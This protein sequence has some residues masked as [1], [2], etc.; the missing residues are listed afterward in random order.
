[1]D[2]A[3]CEPLEEI[4]KRVQFNRIN[5]EGTSLSEEVLFPKVTFNYGW[6]LSSVT[7]YT[8][9]SHTNEQLLLQSSIILFDMLEY[10]E[11]TKHINISSNPNIGPR[12][13]Q[14]C[15]YMIKKVVVTLNS[16]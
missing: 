1:M 4:L 10:Y 9:K 12:G 3:H 13:W 2:Q 7:T 8:R 14:A 5:V 16:K 6:I 11:S 15:S